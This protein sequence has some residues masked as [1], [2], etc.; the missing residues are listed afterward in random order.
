VSS[1]DVIHNCLQDINRVTSKK[2]FR[3]TNNS[4]VFAPPVKDAISRMPDEDIL[5]PGPGAYDVVT[6]F[7]Q[8]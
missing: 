2:D 1:L 7:Y 3:R 5:N 8:V 6:I 4:G